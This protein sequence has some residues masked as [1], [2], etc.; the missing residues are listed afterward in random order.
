MKRLYVKCPSCGHIFPSG[1][2]AES[3]TQLIGFSYLCPRC[4]RIFPCASSEYLEKVD[5]NFE[6]AIKKEEVFALPVGKRIEISG[7]DVF[8]L[9]EE[10]IAKHGVFLSSDKAIISFKQRNDKKA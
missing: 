9:D 8:E 1:F 10:V 4:R 5:E 6:K 3:V 7:P 2:K